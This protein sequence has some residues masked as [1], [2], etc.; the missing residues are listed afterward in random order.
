MR[1]FNLKDIGCVQTHMHPKEKE[2]QSKTEIHDIII[3]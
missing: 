3:K 2:F 1:D